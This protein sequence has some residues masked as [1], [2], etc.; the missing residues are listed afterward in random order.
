MSDTTPPPNG[1]GPARDGADDGSGSGDGGGTLVGIEPIEIQ[2]EM[3]RSFLDYAMSVIVARALPDVRDGL[4]PVHRR[5]LYG[6]HDM[7]AR[8]DRPHLKCARVTGDVM[9]KYHPHGD[10]ALYDALVRMAQPF[11]LRHPF[12]DG[13]GNFGC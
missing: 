12:V 1:D 7:G 10:L 9:G 3:E 4:K 13:H 2:D 5:L 6:M 8:P 11:R